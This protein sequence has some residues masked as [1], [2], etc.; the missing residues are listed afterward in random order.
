MLASHSIHTPGCS[1]SCD[2]LASAGIASG[3]HHTCVFHIHPPTHIHIHTT[4]NLRVASFGEGSFQ[5]CFYR[6]EMSYFQ[7]YTSQISENIKAQRCAPRCHI[8]ASVSEACCIWFHLSAALQNLALSIS[9][10]LSILIQ[11]HS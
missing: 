10:F 4:P 3:H 7:L 11:S 9:L 1:P 5:T 6:Q 2:L 8:L